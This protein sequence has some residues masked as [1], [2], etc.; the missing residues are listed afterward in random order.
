[1]DKSKEL[2]GLDIFFLTDLNLIDLAETRERLNVIA[3]CC[4]E[5]GDESAGKIFSAAAEKIKEK[6]CSM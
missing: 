4:Y 3:T 1:M 6:C 2:T 5:N